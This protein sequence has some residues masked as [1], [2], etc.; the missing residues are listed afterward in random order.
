MLSP[1]TPLTGSV[2]MNCGNEVGKATEAAAKK[3]NV[4]IY[5]FKTVELLKKDAE[6]LRLHMIR[7][8]LTTGPG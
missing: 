8:K 7:T 1:L 3:K 4:E 5:A 2:L 6:N